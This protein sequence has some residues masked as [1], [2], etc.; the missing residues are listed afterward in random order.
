[1]RKLHGY[2][3]LLRL[4]VPYFPVIETRL[5]GISNFVQKNMAEVAVFLS[6]QLACRVSKMP[7][8]NW[9]RQ[10]IVQCQ[11]GI[12]LPFYTHRKEL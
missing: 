1:M 10:P 2:R 9:A 12:I 4:F 11:Y 8:F 7:C 5:H 6:I 3:W